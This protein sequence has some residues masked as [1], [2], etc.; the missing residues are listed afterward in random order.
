[1]NI[2]LICADSERWAVGLRNISAVLKEAGHRARLIF[3]GSPSLAM[4][5]RGFENIR[6]LSEKSDLIGMSSMSR[7]SQRTKTITYALKPLHKQIIWGGMHPTLYPEDCVDHA[8]L[9]CRVER[10][11][12]MLELVDTI[13]SGKDFRHTKNGGYQENGQIA[14]NDVR[15]LISDLDGL[16]P[17]DFSFDDEFHVDGWAEIQPHPSTSPGSSILF[18]GT[19]GC[20]CNC[21]YYSNSQ[22]KI[23]YRDKPAT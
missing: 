9:I 1:M 20:V 21:Y 7:S 23:S 14:L 19:R 3:A 22:L 4:N 6:D 8:D 2:T 5:G 12:F 13:A 18:S 15:P 17:C 16:P 11:E 10:E